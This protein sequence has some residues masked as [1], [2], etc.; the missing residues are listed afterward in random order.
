MSWKAIMVALTITASIPAVS[1]V[2]PSASQGGLPLRIG[3]GFS[4]FNSSVGTDQMLGGALWAD[5]TPAGLPPF[6]NGFGVEAEARYV[7]I[8]QP[9]PRTTGIIHEGTVGAGPTYT[10]LRF[11][12]FRPYGKFLIDFAGQ[13]AIIPPLPYH[14]ETLA[15]YAPGV[16]V[17]YRVFSNLWARAD[18]EYQAWPHP[19]IWPNPSANPNWTLDPNGITVGLSWDLRSMHSHR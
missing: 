17:D 5:F 3:G 9:S 14:H 15:A 4:D 13:E 19:F 12:K 2:V 8:G 1:Q 10:L 6:L 11:R 7:T 18:Y 16:G